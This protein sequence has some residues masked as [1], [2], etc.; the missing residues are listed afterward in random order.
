[1]NQW[2]TI[3]GVVNLG[4]NDD[5]FELGGHSL[6]AVSLMAAIKKDKGIHVPLASLIQNSTV[7]KFAQYLDKETG[8]D[9][10]NCLVPIRPEGSMTPLFLIHG[11]GLNVL[12]YQSLIKHISL[13]RPIFAF[14]ASGLDGNKQMKD[15][16]EDMAKE[17]VS[18]LQKVQPTGP[19]LL[20][21]FS[22]GGF[23]AFEMSHILSSKGY[24]VKL[25]GMIDAVAYLANFS[26][27]WFERTFVRLW[28]A[29]AKPFY[30]IWIYLKEPKGNRSHFLHHKMKSIK[31]KLVYYLT[32]LGVENTGNLRNDIGQFSFMSNKVLVHFNEAL[33]HY[34]LKPA[35]FHIDLFAAG[36]PTFYIFDR[37]NYGWSKFALKGLT[38]HSMPG[39]H[40]SLFAA[41]NDKRFAEILEE[42]LVELETE[43][44]GI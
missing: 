11:A 15:T 3:L 20:L 33:Q 18:E 43:N 17:Y 9:Q 16:L 35:N 42:R 8:F 23:I 29:C 24:E 7:R 27:S 1:V 32:K 25:T 34:K 4:V 2:K 28:S 39:E 38:K 13:N 14:Q 40:S 12:L 6:N 31:L 5:F 36:K 37:E 44:K 22:L 21:G 30:N 41:P 10:W 26:N 19:Y